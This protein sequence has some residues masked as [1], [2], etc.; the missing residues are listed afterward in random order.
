[1]SAVA[2]NVAVPADGDTPAASCTASGGAT[3]SVAWTDAGG[4]PFAGAFAAGQ[5]YTATMTVAAP[6]G[7]VFDAATVVTVDGHVV[8][9][10]IGA[11][12]GT[13]TVQYT[14]LVP[15]NLPPPDSA[16][17]VPT[18]GQWALAGLALMLGRLVMPAA[19]GCE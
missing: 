12:G 13:V 14:F 19:A 6:A 9:P 16:A 8:T 10:A 17:A 3:C 5:S 1:M 11:A 15:L 18:L 2:V 4:A 7:S